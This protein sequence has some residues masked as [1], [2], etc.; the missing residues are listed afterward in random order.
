MQSQEQQLVADPRLAEAVSL[1]NRGS[2]YAAHDGFEELW[3]ETDAPLRSVL[4]GI[5]QIA[6]AQLHLE[7]GNHHGATVLMGEGLGR[8]RQSDPGALGLNIAELIAL[9]QPRLAALQR[10]EDLT[11]FPEPVLEAL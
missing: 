11:L 8:L 3:H 6:V 10:G 2:W 4:Q 5:L 1:F 9:V 7:R